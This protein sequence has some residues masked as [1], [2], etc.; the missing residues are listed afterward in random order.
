MGDFIIKDG[1]LMKYTGQGGKVVVP[2]NVKI[3]NWKAF[4]GNDKIISIE[5]PDDVLI[6]PNAFLGCKGLADSNK[7]VIVHGCIFDYFGS[8]K[9]LVIPDGITTISCN[10]FARNSHKYSEIIIPD[11][12][13]TLMGNCFGLT[14][15]ES[16]LHAKNANLV[17]VTMSDALAKA[18]GIPG[19]K[20]NFD[21]NSLTLA[22]LKDPSRFAGELKSI[23]IKIILKKRDEYARSIIWSGN[24][25]FM[26]HFLSLQKSVSVKD[27]DQY[28][29][30]AAQTGKQSEMVAFLLKYKET[31]FDRNAVENAQQEELEKE[32]GIK[33]RTLSDWRKIFKFSI[34]N[35]E[36]II[37][38]YK[39]EDET[40]IIPDRI[41]NNIVVGIGKD[42]FTTG[43]AYK[44]KIYQ[45]PETIK[46]IGAG[47]FHGCSVEHIDLPDNL[48]DIGEEAFIY[49]WL[50]SIIIP[51]GIKSL[52]VRS[53]K[54]CKKLENVVFQE[55]LEE[56]QGAAFSGCES[57]I[58]VKTPNS[59][60]FIDQ[61]AFSDCKKL[62]RF[63]ITNPETKI[64]DTAFEW[65]SKLTIQAPAGSY[66]EQYAK[67]HNIP[68]VAE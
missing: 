52:P 8:K 12:V 49:S 40:L 13:T 27:I 34:K 29:E 17:S 53:F 32:L 28:I 35:S 24:M 62:E 14:Y 50:K 2:S 65:T 15:D 3:I 10:A 63:V 41:G 19:L 59:L 43:Q 46:S 57:L 55:G 26:G 37:S 4:S 60:R 11:S 67:E 23:L 45:L 18:L 31:A 25:A 21:I 36:V 54:N 6:Q 42:A 16:P 22:L 47:T 58:E 68:F 9:R 44:V 56:I 48:V 5:I 61:W 1:T 39:G 38:G 64:M 30:Y 51:A 7:F 66:A 20:G 33:E